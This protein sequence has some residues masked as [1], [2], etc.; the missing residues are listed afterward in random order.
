M[1]T[2]DANRTGVDVGSSILDSTHIP[3]SPAM[4]NTCRSFIF[5]KD[6]AATF[7]SPQFLITGGTGFIGRHVVQR[8][9]SRGAQVRVF[10]RTPEKARRLFGDRVEIACGDL[11][12][13]SSVA[14]AVEG[15]DT[16]IHLGATFQFG[17][18]AQRAN[19]ETNIFGTRYLLEAS[20]RTGIQRFVH[21]SSCG[22]LEGN[23]E[24]L[25]ERDFPTHVS[26]KESYRRSK[27]L[28]E[29][30]ALEAVRRGLPVTI[31]TPTSPLGAGDEAPTPTGRIVQDYLRGRFPFGARVGLNFIHVMDLAEGIL[32][33]AER[34]RTGERYLLGHHNVWLDEFLQLLARLTKRSAPRFTLPQSVITLAGGIGEVVGSE[35]ICRETAAHA[36]RRQWFDFSKAAQ[37]LGWSAWTSLET[38]TLEAV[39]WFQGVATPNQDPGLA[40]KIKWRLA[41]RLGF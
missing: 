21:I 11:R 7:A 30:E 6:P 29:M 24:R 26:C 37:E 28:G 27:W 32:A 38:I 23:H 20:E 25:T 1:P 22:V 17:P 14:L 35:R 5:H 33:V 31:A 3:R 34:G 40:D 16:V 39:H 2:S 41:N 8:L 15:C 9:L 19:L 12:D 4:R 18:R 10:C 36:R 13:R